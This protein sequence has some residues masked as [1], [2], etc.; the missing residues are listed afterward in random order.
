M[1]CHEALVHAKSLGLKTAF[2]DH[3]LFGFADGSSIVTNKLLELA[4]ADADHVI[5]VSYTR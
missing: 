1:S 4:L 2:T 3:S 5:C